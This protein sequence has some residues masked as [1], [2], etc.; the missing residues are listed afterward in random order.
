MR[1]ERNS[2]ESMYVP[3]RSQKT[4]KNALNSRIVFF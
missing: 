4:F 2:F 1:I 3:S